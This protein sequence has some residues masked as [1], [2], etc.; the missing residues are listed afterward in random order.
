VR[1]ALRTI[2]IHNKVLLI[3]FLIY[4]SCVY[5]QKFTDNITIVNKDENDNWL[6]NLEKQETNTQKV[7]VA[8]RLLSDTL[9]YVK[10]TGDRIKF[11]P[12][13]DSAKVDVRC[14]PQIIFNGI[15]LYIKNRTPTKS[16]RELS[17][18]LRQAKINK[19]EIVRDEKATA[20]YGTQGLCGLILISSDDKKLRKQVKKLE[21]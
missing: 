18:L 14:R 1:N 7:L 3:I 15:P 6:T 19:I 16:V 20:L 11:K 21:L 12:Q 10:A 5:G 13:T 8:D 9:A 17:S 2:M 4:S